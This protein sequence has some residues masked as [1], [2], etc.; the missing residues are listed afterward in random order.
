MISQSGYQTFHL[1][2]EVD[3]PVSLPVTLLGLSC[4]QSLAAQNYKAPY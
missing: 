2:G 4:I 1:Q 3:V